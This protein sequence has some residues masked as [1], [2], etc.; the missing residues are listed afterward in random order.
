MDGE[1]TSEAASAPTLSTQSSRSLDALDAAISH[2][3]T[4]DNGTSQISLE[5]ERGRLKVW[6]SNLGALQPAASPKSLDHR[7]RDAPLM[8]KSVSTGLNRVL[9]SVQRGEPRFPYAK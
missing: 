5:D 9:L 6:A 8:R 7:L 2:A 3:K 4:Y 1:V